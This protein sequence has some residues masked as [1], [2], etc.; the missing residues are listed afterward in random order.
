MIET[1]LGLAKIVFL[2][3]LFFLMIA[4]EYGGVGQHTKRDSMNCIDDG[5]KA[6]HTVTNSRFEALL[7]AIPTAVFG[8]IGVETVAITAYEAKDRS[9]VTRPAR[10]IAWCIAALYLLSAFGSVLNVSWIDINLPRLYSG[11]EKNSGDS[12]CMTAVDQNSTDYSAKPPAIIALEN[13]GSAA[14]RNVLVACLIFVVLS[15]ANAALY[16]A[17]RTLFGLTRNIDR[18][19]RYPKKALI[20]LSFVTH[21]RSQRFGVSFGQIPAGALIFSILVFCW[22]P[23][24]GNATVQDVLSSIGTVGSLLVW[25]SQALA[26]IRFDYLYVVAENRAMFPG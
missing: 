2:I 20:W 26:Y 25:A 11:Q 13:I 18:N 24:I 19:S 21:D 1:V 17:S 8:F 16:V 4:I 10:Y 6:N 15:A 22:L 5:F 12:Q 23:F 14:G 3:A 7:I 9:Q